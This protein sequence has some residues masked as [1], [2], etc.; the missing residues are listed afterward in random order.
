MNPPSDVVYDSDSLDVDNSTGSR[1]KQV[2]IE[3]LV[4]DVNC[5][6]DALDVSND[7][8]SRVDAS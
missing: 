4:S 6:S 3:G 5:D 1:I 2:K 7:I 8:G